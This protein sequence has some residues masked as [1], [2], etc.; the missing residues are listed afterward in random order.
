MPDTIPLTIADLVPGQ[1]Y[2]V[3]YNTDDPVAMTFLD[4]DPVMGVV[5]LFMVDPDNSDD[6]RYDAMIHAPY[7]GTSVFPLPVPHWAAN[8][9]LPDGR[10][11]NVVS[12]GTTDV[13]VWV[14]ADSP[15]PTVTVWA[16]KLTVNP[17]AI[18]RDP[19]VA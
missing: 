19:K 1:R 13:A 16:D 12:W 17:D 15:R 9:T 18:D 8:V 6:G 2:I 10:T 4:V 11:G 7:I 5:A 3:D 14:H